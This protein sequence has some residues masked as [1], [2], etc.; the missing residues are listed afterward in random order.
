MFSIKVEKEKKKKL[1]WLA[2]WVGME[3]SKAFDEKQRKKIFGK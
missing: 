2:G 1:F 3:S